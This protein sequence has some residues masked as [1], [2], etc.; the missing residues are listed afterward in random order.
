[1]AAG[2]TPAGLAEEL[3]ALREARKPLITLEELK[4]KRYTVNPSHLSDVLDI[5]KIAN[6]QLAKNLNVDD[7]LVS[8]WRGGT[9][10]LNSKN[11]LFFEVLDYL[12]LRLERSLETSPDQKQL[13]ASWLVQQEAAEQRMTQAIAEFLDSTILLSQMPQTAAFGEMSTLQERVRHNP[14]LAAYFEKEDRPQKQ[15]VYHGNWGIC[16]ASVRFLIEAI[17]SQDLCHLKLYSNQNMDWLTQDRDFFAAWGFL[18]KLLLQRGHKVTIIHSLDRSP[19]EMV[20]GLRSWLPVYTQGKI[21]PYCLNNRTGEEVLPPVKTLFINS[22]KTAIHSDAFAG[23]EDQALV[24]YTEGQR[25]LAALEAQFDLLQ[26]QSIR[27]G[28]FYRGKEAQE[29]FSSQTD[30]AY[31]ERFRDADFRIFNSSLPIYV[32]LPET[33]KLIFANHTPAIKD[34]SAED[35]QRRLSA[36][37]ANLSAFLSRGNRIQLAL[38]DHCDAE[39]FLLDLFPLSYQQLSLPAEL[40]PSLYQSIAAWAKEQTNVDLFPL[41]EVPFTPLNLTLVEDEYVQVMLR[42]PQDQL[43]VQIEHPA[44]LTAFSQYLDILID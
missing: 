5:L 30:P 8:R 3:Q 20:M 35:W 19:L 14:Y 29:Y 42:N 21:E 24:F 16:E 38:P 15:P 11:P 6:N 40:F 13:L 34:F 33:R 2:K 26:E 10:S 12:M 1:M 37:Q 23:M 9:R 41:R 43:L 44:F 36:S 18:M 27:L 7:S 31:F 17:Q 22:G 39:S 4:Q 25:A 32:L 28:Y